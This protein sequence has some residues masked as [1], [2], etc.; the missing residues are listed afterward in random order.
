MSYMQEATT[1]GDIL[2]IIL[3]FGIGIGIMLIVDY[4]RADE[5][6]EEKRKREETELEQQRV[7]QEQIQINQQIIDT[8]QM[9]Y[10]MALKYYY[11]D[12]YV[13]KEGVF[14]YTDKGKNKKYFTLAELD[15]IKDKY[16][17][18]MKDRYGE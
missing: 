8:Y 5:L 13:D 6:K 12:A 18:K 16:D 1:G 9:E 7:L 4:F 11:N 2:G 10:G 15:D 17:K 3:V 14:Q